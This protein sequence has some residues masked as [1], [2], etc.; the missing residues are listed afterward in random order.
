MGA[1]AALTLAADQLTKWWALTALADGNTIPVVWTLRFALHYNTGA[2]FSMGAESDWTRFLPLLVLAAVAVVVWRAGAAMSRLGAISV[3]LVIGGAVGNLADRALRLDGG[4]FLSGAVV[5]F[6]DLDWW[7]VFNIAD[8]GVVVG[9]ILF[10]LVS[11]RAPEPGAGEPAPDASP[12]EPGEHTEGPRT[13][14]GNTA[15]AGSGG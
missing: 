15:V 9:A 3:G 11:L 7:P 8:S 1:V 13:D 6:I 14:T 5:D 10:A 2:A 12:V 4:G